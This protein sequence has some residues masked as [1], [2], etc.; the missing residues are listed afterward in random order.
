MK[1]TTSLNT[2]FSTICWLFSIFII[3]IVL[4]SGNKVFA[5]NLTATASKGNLPTTAAGTWTEVSSREINID[6]NISDVEK[7][8]IVTT[9]SVKSEDRNTHN[10]LSR[11][12]DLSHN[13]ICNEISRSMP[14]QSDY[15]IASLGFN[16]TDLSKTDYYY[17]K[18]IKI[19]KQK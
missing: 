6:A 3:L 15:G 19:I 18:T 5:D 2:M 11:L 12:K 9:F 14:S 1:R 4:L 17:C 13:Q 8:M 7:V 16:L 10:D